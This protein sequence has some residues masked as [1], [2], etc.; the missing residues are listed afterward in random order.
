MEYTS[1]EQFVYFVFVIYVYF[2][3]IDISISQKKIGSKRFEIFYIRSSYV[4]GTVGDRSLYNFGKKKIKCFSFRASIVNLLQIQISTRSWVKPFRVDYFHLFRFCA[5][6][7]SYIGFK[8]MSFFFWS[9]KV[10]Q[11]FHL[12]YSI[13]RKLDKDVIL[14]T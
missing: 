13:D 4:A 6:K 11:T 5:K 10:L 8:M 2:S 7:R 12:G 1:R 3:I 14:S 9:V